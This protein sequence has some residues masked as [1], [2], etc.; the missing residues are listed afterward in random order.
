MCASGAP[1]AL[2]G[3][4]S[5][6]TVPYPAQEITTS[7][8]FEHSQQSRVHLQFLSGRTQPMRI[9]QLTF[10]PA[11]M[12]RTKMTNVPRPTTVRRGIRY[13][14]NLQLLSFGKP[15]RNRSVFRFAPPPIKVVRIISMAPQ[16]RLWLI[17]QLDWLDIA[18]REVANSVRALRRM[19]VNRFPIF[20]KKQLINI[21]KQERRGILSKPPASDLPRAVLPKICIPISS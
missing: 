20:R 5:P 19:N 15:T 9:A 14:M 2:Y 11:H 17:N 13:G 7:E 3:E 12:K 10:T 6:P 21:A 8:R 1:I 4:S 16:F 18:C